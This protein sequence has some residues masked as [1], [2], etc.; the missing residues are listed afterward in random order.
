ML[1]AKK[2]RIRDN[3]ASEIADASDKVKVAAGPSIQLWVKS[4]IKAARMKRRMKAAMGLLGMWE[5]KDTSF[6]DR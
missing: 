5:N 4:P 2:F 1:I 3:N 6:F